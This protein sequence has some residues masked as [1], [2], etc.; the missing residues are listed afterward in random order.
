MNS[1]KNCYII[2]LVG[3]LL[4]LVQSAWAESFAGETK[5]LA[6]DGAEGDYFGFDVALSDDTAVIGAFKDDDDV[7]G[8]NSGS[9]YVFTRSGNGWHQQAKLTATGGAAN[10]T[11]GGKVAISGDMIVI[12]AA[13][14]DDKGENSG[15]AYVFTRSGANWRQQAKLIADDGAM[16]NA[17]GQSIVISGDTIII[18]A[19]HDDDKGSDSGSVYVF[20]RTGKSW[21]QQA[22][23]TA[24]DGAA[25]DVFGISVAMSGNTMIVGA[26]LNDEKALNAGAVYVFIRSGNQWHQQAKLTASDGAETDIFG[27]RVALSGDTALISARRDD[28]DVMGVDAGSAYIFTRNR[29]V[30]SQQA[31]LTATDGAA[32]D[33]FGRS[34]ALS[35]DVAV[36]GAMFQDDMGDK[37]GA[38][39]VFSRV[40]NTW[41]Q[42]AKLIAADGAAGDALGW[43]I[44]LSGG[45]ALVGAARDDDKGNE[46][47]SAY[48]FDINRD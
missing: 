14:A 35:G 6:A 42:R 41:S 31:K 18:G 12:G 4:L 20:S 17:F 1:A 11:F 2:A 33:R 27:V 5:L 36:I 25:G 16:G 37:S 28:D 44:A 9:A 29:T 3:V 47:G 43:S 40:G 32:N 8:V 26:D 22:K 46:S 7:K 15:S 23:L 48:I 34:V 24:S 38:A 10:D 13:F 19:P 30:W 45:T 21:H 39:Y